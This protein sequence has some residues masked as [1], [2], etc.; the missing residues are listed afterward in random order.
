MKQVQYLVEALALYILYFFFSLLPPDKASDIGGWIGRKI[1]PRMGATRKADKHLSTALP[2]L[3]AAEREKA[4]LEMWDNLGRVVA[5]Y[6]HLEFISRERTEIHGRSIVEDLIES[7]NGAIFIAAHLANWEVD[8]AA[9]LTQFGHPI[10]LTYRAPNNPWVDHLIKH[11]RTLGGQLKAHP[12]SRDSG[13][14]IIS[15][16]KEKRYL[17]ILID[18]KYNEGVAADFFGQ[19]AMTNPVFAQLAQKYDC[20]V[21]PVRNERTG[22]AQ[23]RLTVHEPL[24]LDASVDDVIKEAHRLLEMWIKDRPGQWLWLHRRWMTS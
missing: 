1:G 21:I 12:K 14:H 3:S 16:L 19:P 10:E 9:L 5:E 2:E 17:G 20:P 4:I 23:F 22:P 24:D 11:A 8:C 15:A 6:P 13:R 18:Q 7:G